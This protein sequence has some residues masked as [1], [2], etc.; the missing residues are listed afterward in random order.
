MSI[1]LSSKE[2]G[3][4]TPK[5][6]FNYFNKKY[7][8]TLDPCASP[9]NAL[10]DKFYTEADDGLAQS[11]RD[12]VVFMNPPY[13]R[14]IEK[15]VAKAYT[16]ALEN[17]AIVVCLLPARTCTDWFWKYCAKGEIRFLKGRITFMDA[18]T[19]MKPE[20]G[21]TFPSVIV[22]FKKNHFAKIF[23]TNELAAG[24]GQTFSLDHESMKND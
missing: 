11:W 1:T 12:E 13:G 3:W 16:E 19:G 2:K 6:L 4:R 14:E 17:N 21:A 22:I 5:Y 18:T 23:G 24:N 15:W 10:V 7:N 8:F 20:N 9:E